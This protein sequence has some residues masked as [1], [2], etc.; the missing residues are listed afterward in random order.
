MSIQAIVLI[1]LVWTVAGFLAAIAFGKA[2]Q[3]TNESPNAGIPK[4]H[5]R[6]LP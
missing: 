6:A 2:I 1:L 3:K 5:Q 4:K